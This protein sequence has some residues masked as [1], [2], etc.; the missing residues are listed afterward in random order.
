MVVSFPQKELGVQYIRDLRGSHHNFAVHVH[1][2]VNA[3]ESASAHWNEIAIRKV[4]VFSP[5]SGC[6]V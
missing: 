4:S 6:A 5:E 2:R 1:E 3:T